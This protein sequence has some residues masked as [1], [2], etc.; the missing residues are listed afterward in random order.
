M[1]V[2]LVIPTDHLQSLSVS[3]GGDNTGITTKHHAIFSLDDGMTVMFASGGPAVIRDGDQVVVVG[4]KKG[5][6]MKCDAYWN[7]TAHV[8]GN[9]GRWGSLAV[10][11]FGLMFGVAILSVLFWPIYLI[12]F[13]LGFIEKL[14]VIGLGLFFCGAGLYHLYSWLRIS[15]AVKALEKSY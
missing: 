4:R 14:I 11:L 8:R 13:P 7:I 6:L 12:G 5:R 15:N 3:G 2:C 9:A 10:A 1:E